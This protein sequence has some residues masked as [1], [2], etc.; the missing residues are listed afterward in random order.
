MKE[1]KQIIIDT[2]PGVDDAIALMYAFNSDDLDIKLISSAGGNGPIENLTANA[3]FLTELFKKDNRRGSVCLL[4][5]VP[6]AVDTVFQK[7]VFHHSQQIY[8]RVQ[9]KPRQGNVSQRPRAF[10]KNRKLGPGI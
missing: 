8:H 2:D 7:R 4:Q 3:I 1:R 9:D 10:N 5:Y 6:S